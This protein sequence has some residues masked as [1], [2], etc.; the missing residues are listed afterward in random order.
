MGKK[1]CKKCQKVLAENDLGSHITRSDIQII[2]E[3]FP[4]EC[5][6]CLDAD[7]LLELNSWMNSCTCKRDG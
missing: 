7:A 2:N 4:D 3:M 6:D 5:L 1:V